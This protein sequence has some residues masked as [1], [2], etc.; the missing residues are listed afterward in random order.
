MLQVRVH[1]RLPLYSVPIVPSLADRSH[2]A[3]DDGELIGG[4]MLG[5]LKSALRI[6]VS[7]FILPAYEQHLCT[8]S[9]TQSIASNGTVLLLYR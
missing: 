7:C 1:R 5:K 6:W 3:A 8:A 9:K 4:V 2:D